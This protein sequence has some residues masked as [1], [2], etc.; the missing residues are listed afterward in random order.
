MRRSAL[1]VLLSLLLSCCAPLRADSSGQAP[2]PSA[3]NTRSLAADD[4][5]A[6]PDDVKKDEPKKDEPKKDEAKKDEAKEKDAAK[7][8]EPKRDD[9]KKDDSKED[10]T[11]KDEAKKDS[12]KPAATS[13]EKLDT[14]EVRRGP[15]KIDVGLKGTFEPRRVTSISLNVKQWNA[16]SVLK[17]VKHGARVERGDLLVALETEKIDQAIDDLRTQIRLTDI[18]LSKGRQ[19][20]AALEKLTP[21]DLAAALRNERILRED[22]DRFMK[23]ELPTARKAAEHYLK[24]YADNLAY[25]RE[26]LAQLEKMY[27]ADDLTEETEEIVL[28]RARD[29]VKQAEF[30]YELAKMRHEQT[31]KFSLPREEEGV[32]DAVGRER[33]S[34]AKAKILLPLALERQKLA[35]G[36]AEVERARAEEKLEEL[37]A[38]RAA[39]T[40]KAPVDG[41]VYY[42]KWVDGVWS[43]ATASDQFARGTALSANRVFMSIVQM[44]PL[45]IRTQTPEKDLQYVRAGL[46]GV[47]RPVAYPDE[48]IPVVVANV[49][50]VPGAGASFDTTL[51]LVGKK[52]KNLWPGMTCLVTLPGYVKKKALLVP[53]GAVGTDP[54]DDDVHFVYRVG[55]DGKPKKQP[56]K[57]GKRTA[58]DV[59]ILGGLAEGDKVL[60]DAS[61]PPKDT[62]KKTAKK[63]QN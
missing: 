34:L 57:L 21:M 59:E 11:K 23:V 53:P 48:R 44:Q 6:E 33:L 8:D 43:G 38:D 54:L 15:L 45:R 36:R 25:E 32:K 55:K 58:K 4:V 30:S 9:A 3:D 62:E 51:T 27:K 5:A 56:V 7:E 42:G 40:V 26:E 37:L 20:L 10:E 14:C 12:V 63:K 29:A 61:K 19:E 47:A 35:I 2:A 17:A 28:R 60:S 13:P 1:A 39:M 16:L 41:V 46:E 18:E 50:D 49:A 22:F 31:M 52:A 24:T